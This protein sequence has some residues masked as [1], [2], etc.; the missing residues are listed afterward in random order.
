MPSRH[1]CPIRSDVEAVAGEDL[2]LP[3][4][5]Q[6]VGILG[7]EDMGQQAGAG[8]ALLDRARGQR[9]LVDAPC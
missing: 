4:E 2:A 3:V 9:H 1:A 7:D 5:R 8:P 6:V